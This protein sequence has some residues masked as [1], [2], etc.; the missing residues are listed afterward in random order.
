M[1]YQFSY[2]RDYFKSKYPEDR[3]MFEVVPVR[4]KLFK[5]VRKAVR[6]LHYFIANFGDNHPELVNLD[7]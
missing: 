7:D 6:R 2:I 4:S 3:D 1:K 5:I